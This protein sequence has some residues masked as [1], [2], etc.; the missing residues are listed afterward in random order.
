ML[1]KRTLLIILLTSF[2]C[3][4]FNSFIIQVIKQRRTDNNDSG[5][6]LS[7]WVAWTPTC[8]RNCSEPYGYQMR[9]RQCLH[10][11]HNECF[12]SHF[13]SCL[14]LNEKLDD[15]RPCYNGCVIKVTLTFG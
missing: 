13:N 7:P 9:N 11:V 4:S 15:I 12:V 5:F 1:N 2:C 14:F 10:C 3:C 8:K 6:L